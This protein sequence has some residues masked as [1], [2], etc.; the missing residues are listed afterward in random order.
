[1]NLFRT[2]LTLVRDVDFVLFC[3]YC[4]CLS[5]APS[6][7]VTK[8]F[9]SCYNWAGRVGMR[10][11]QERISTNVICMGFFSNDPAFSVFRNHALQPCW[12]HLISYADLMGSFVMV[13]SP[14]GSV[15]SPLLFI[16][17]TSDMPEVIKRNYHPLMQMTLLFTLHWTTEAGDGLWGPGSDSRQ[18]ATIPNPVSVE[19]VWLIAGRCRQQITEVQTTKIKV[20][21]IFE[22]QNNKHHF[23]SD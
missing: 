18:G 8:L 4:H 22:I 15:L 23:Y 9:G 20:K 13:G 7:L 12:K 5:L 17:Q 19:K 14:R 6:Q 21:I 2:F 3:Q 1:M 11:G 16:I 10:K